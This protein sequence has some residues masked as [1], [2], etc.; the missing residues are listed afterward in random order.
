[1]LGVDFFSKKQ[2][3]KIEKL[4]VS[5]WRD[6]RAACLRCLEKE[7]EGG[8]SNSRGVVQHPVAFF[9]FCCLVQYTERH[10]G[11]CE[12]GHVGRFSH[13]GLVEIDFRQK[14]IKT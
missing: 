4:S 9:L 11:C 10:P 3:L 1:M 8:G 5:V 2:L 12:E 7:M 6:C 14:T 13:T